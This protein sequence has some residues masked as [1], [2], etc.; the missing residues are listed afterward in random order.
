MATEWEELRAEVRKIKDRSEE[1]DRQQSTED[2]RL[3]W[4]EQAQIEEERIEKVWVLERKN[5]R[6]KRQIEEVQGEKGYME[7]KMEEKIKQI[8]QTATEKIEVMREECHKLEKECRRLQ[9]QGLKDGNTN[10]KNE[11]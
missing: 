8:E 10:E 1:K 11:K 4:F 2:G 7:R 3:N 9:G 5:E 6:L